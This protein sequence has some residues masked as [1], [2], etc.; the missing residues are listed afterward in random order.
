MLSTDNDSDSSVSLPA[1]QPIRLSRSASRQSRSTVAMQTDAVGLAKQLASSIQQQLQ[2]TRADARLQF[3]EARRL[4]KEAADR[5]E[6]VVAEARRLQQAAVDREERE[7]QQTFDR[8]RLQT[9]AATAREDRLFAQFNLFMEKSRS[10]LTT[11]ADLR[12]K[13]ARLEI[14]LE[15]ATA[16]ATAAAATAAAQRT[17]TLDTPVTTPGVPSAVT[18]VSNVAVNEFQP[19]RPIK[20]VETAAVQNLADSVCNFSEQASVAEQTNPVQAT[21]AYIFTSGVTQMVP[22]S[23]FSTSADTGNLSTRCDEILRTQVQNPTFGEF[24]TEN[25]PVQNFNNFLP[26]AAT[27]VE[28]VQILFSVNPIHASNIHSALSSAASVMDHQYRS[29]FHTRTP[30]FPLHLTSDSLLP[31]NVTNSA[32]IVNNQ[33]SQSVTCS[34]IPVPP[35]QGW[36]QGSFVEA[37]PEVEAERSRRR[38][39]KAA[40]FLTEARQGRGRGREFEAE[41]RQTKLEA[42]PRRGREKSMLFVSLGSTP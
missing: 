31:R 28:S 41:A 34:D 15:Q 40:M 37:E 5:E 25:T 18:T 36:A 20:N 33:Y 11:A 3:D 39:G 19:A 26:P 2:D 23:K 30:D 29:T 17:A 6:R 32:V 1:T 14:Q 22:T 21:S 8:E 10:D 42:R 27:A 7:S 9:E 13:T 24:L 38:R 35:D 12:A 4:Q 16:A